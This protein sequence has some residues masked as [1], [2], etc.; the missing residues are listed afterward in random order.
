MEMGFEETCIAWFSVIQLTALPKSSG[1]MPKL[2][3]AR[4]IRCDVLPWCLPITWAKFMLVSY[5][6][7][8]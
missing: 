8:S 2:M 7:T 1:F 6:L 4:K 5:Q 3:M